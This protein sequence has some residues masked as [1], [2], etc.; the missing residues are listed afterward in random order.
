ML[1]TV[2]ARRRPTS[3]DR[4]RHLLDVGAGLFATRPYESVLMEEIAERAAF[5]GALGDL[6]PRIE[7]NRRGV[8]A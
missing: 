3:Q 4:R 8:H 2:P 6:V 7:Q 5:T 1:G